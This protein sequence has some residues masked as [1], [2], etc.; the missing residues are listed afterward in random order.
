MASIANMENEYREKYG[1]IPE[2]KDD[3]LNYIKENFKINEI[4]LKE[5]EDHIDQM[6]WK[7]LEFSI[8]LVPKG[9]PRPRYS[10]VSKR[11]YVKDAANYK[12][13]I[14]DIITVKEIIH[15]GCIIEID[16]YHPTPT[17]LM[18]P[19]E[20]YLAEAGKI[21]ALVNPDVDNLAK[22]YLDAITGHLI[23]NDNIVFSAYL[24]KHY[25]I[26]PR[27]VITLKYQDDFDCRYNMK[28]ITGSKSYKTLLG[29]EKLSN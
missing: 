23:I 20:I 12:K 17:S 19:E 22:T 6:E 25:S 13:L 7:F 5:L 8:P 21:P 4:K 26:K 3:I 18:R 29:S 27:I 24:N 10:S 11:F 15:T 9:T 16:T 2:E 1:V 14:K 28:R